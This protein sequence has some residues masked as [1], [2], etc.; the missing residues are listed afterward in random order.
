MV[1]SELFRL[2]SGLDRELPTPGRNV[3]QAERDEYAA[4]LPLGLYVYTLGLGIACLAGAGIAGSAVL[5]GATGFNAVTYSVFAVAC[6][7]IGSVF[8]H[9]VIIATRERNRARQ[10]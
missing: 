9:G 6:A 5:R 8:V 3:T 1:L 2:R 10:R 7:F 4:S